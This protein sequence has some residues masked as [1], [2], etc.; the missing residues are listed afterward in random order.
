M[1][2]V[3]FTMQ[4]DSCP[5]SDSRGWKAQVLRRERQKTRLRVSSGLVSGLQDTTESLKS[6]VQFLWC[7]LP[8]VIRQVIV[9]HCPFWEVAASHMTFVCQV[10]QTAMSVQHSGA[11]CSQPDSLGAQGIICGTCLIEVGEEMERIPR[12]SE[13]WREQLKTQLGI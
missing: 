9:P 4:Q 8:S 10:Y 7:N 6:L 12:Q 13:F 5:A 2:D 11:V 3:F 1:G